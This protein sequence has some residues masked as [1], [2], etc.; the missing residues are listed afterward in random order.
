MGIKLDIGSGG[1]KRPGHIGIDKLPPSENFNHDIDKVVDIETETWPFADNSVSHMFSS[2]VFEHVKA[3]N[4]AHIF[5]EMSRIAMDGA[6]IEIWNPYV[7]H[8]DAHVL[9]HINYLSEEIYYHICCGQQHRWAEILKSKWYIKKIRY[10]CDY[11]L[12]ECLA[13]RGIDADFAI[14]HMINIVKEF[15]MFITVDKS[16]SITTPHWVFE[17]ELCSEIEV[18]K[19]M[20]ETRDLDLVLLSTGQYT[21]TRATLK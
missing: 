3:E 8:R 2:H 10:H 7:W 16:D 15:G 21:P 18:H 4:M 17:R 19:P 13:S 20:R 12:L 14:N 5:Q 1:F 6:I 9:G 11:H